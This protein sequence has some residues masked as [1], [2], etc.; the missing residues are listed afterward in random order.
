MVFQKP[1]PFPAMS[2]H[3]NVIAGHTLVGRLARADAEAIVE[4]CL[5]RVALWDEVKD[6]LKTSAMSLSGGQQPR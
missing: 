6:R 3:D 2:I 1:T 4:S 5:Q